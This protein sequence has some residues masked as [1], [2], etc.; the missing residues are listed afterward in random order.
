MC[1]ADGNISEDN[2]MTWLSFLFDALH[3]SETNT[4]CPVCK[5]FSRQSV[6][7]KNKGQAVLCPH[8]K[9]LYVI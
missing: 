6:A 4:Q 7:K 9:S 3:S 5:K 1:Y 2:D 8:C